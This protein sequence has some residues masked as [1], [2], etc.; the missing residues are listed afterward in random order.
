MSYKP[1]VLKISIIMLIFCSSLVTN[2]QHKIIDSLKIQ[3]NK[4]KQDTVK[5]ELFGKLAYQYIN[6]NID[7][8][9]VYSSRLYNLSNLIKSE[10]FKVL[11]SLHKGT[12]FMF[13]NKYDSAH[14][15]YQL[16]IKQADKAKTSKS[17]F[18]SNLGILYKRQ[19]KLEK[20]LELYL[21]GYQYDKENNDEY[22]QF[23][24]LGNISNLYRYWED[25]ENFIKY[26][27]EAIEISDKTNDKRILNA[28]GIITN[29]IGAFYTQLENYEEA[30]KYFKK[31]L[32]QNL[33]IGNNK[34]IS[35]NFNNIGAV[36]SEL[37]NP[38][39]AIP[40]LKKALKIRQELK[41][42]IELV[43]TNMCLGSA[44]GK[45]GNK[46]ISQSYFN[47]AMRIAKGLNNIPL[48]S[49]TYLAISN[50][51][52][53]NNQT[54][55]AHENYKLHIAYR[56][57]VF[58]L[59]NQ[60]NKNDIEAKYETEK[61]DKELAEQKLTLEQQ[62]LEL[63]KKKT[64]YSYMTGTVL[65][66]LVGSTL[67]W[68]L[69]QQRQ[70]RK[71]QEIL[72][73]KREQQVQTLESLIEGEEKERFR[74][75]K[76]L[77]DG[78][79]VDLSTIKYKLT[80]L[81]EKNNQVINEAVA[82][83]DKSCEQVRAISH[84]LV[85]PAL[86]NF[87]LIEAIEDYMGTMNTIHE[88]E[89]NFHHIGDAIELSKKVEINIFRIVQELVNNS[90]KHANANEIN[91]QLSHRENLLQLTIE[92]D[93]E[94]FNKDAV[95]SEGIGLKNIQS[96]VDYLNAKMDFDT[97]AKGTS[98]IIEINTTELS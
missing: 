24:K 11:S 56:D 92:D 63:Q 66:L 50:T 10:K 74:I 86:K 62:E 79:N 25:S 26:S 54:L 46:K 96:R 89:I 13:S 28:V 78:V 15:Y 83:I 98:Y 39:E 4:S 77:H 8:S 80:S 3:L 19:G 75:A 5:A 41:D 49:E 2:G 76:E 48:I 72:T 70:K 85:P 52:L 58:N 61:K 64:Q 59:E 30:L 21:E 65:L 7:S 23:F 1:I 22:G 97:S 53:E 45:K 91:V 88:P 55:K 14:Y 42:E 69:F 87:S 40:Y 82:M 57:S 84:N 16:G 31:S 94:G 20:A 43:E 93:G 33:K 71:N 9:L 36:Y 27:E 29:N 32:E 6:V 81:L 18:Y 68:L 73:L 35:R 38:D 47:E 67:L 51:Y 34:E 17:A 37:N 60:K 95:T 90:V 12:A 44:Y